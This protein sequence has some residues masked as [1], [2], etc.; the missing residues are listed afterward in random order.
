LAC[1]PPTYQLCCSACLEGSATSPLGKSLSPHVSLYLF[2]QSLSMI[3]QQPLLQHQLVVGC[4]KV[5][6]FSPAGQ[7]LWPASVVVA[8][9]NQP[10][11]SVA[12]PTYIRPPT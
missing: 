4:T 10:Q 11:V 5:C 3:L 12:T 9:T 7:L 6:L 2:L 8:E 1:L